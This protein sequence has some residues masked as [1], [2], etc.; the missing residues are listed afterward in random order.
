MGDD[1]NPAEHAIGATNWPGCEP[2]FPF[3]LKFSTQGVESACT[4]TKSSMVRPCRAENY[5]LFVQLR[6]YGAMQLEAQSNAIVVLQF[7]QVAALFV[8]LVCYQTQHY[9]QG[10]LDSKV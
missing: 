5:L 9:Y 10:R 4:A 1:C 2:K 3:P 8:L 7:D 6:F